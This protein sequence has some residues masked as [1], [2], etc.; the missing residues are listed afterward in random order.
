MA[1]PF[2]YLGFQSISWTCNL[3]P[4]WHDTSETHRNDHVSDKWFQHGGRNENCV[5][6]RK[7]ISKYQKKFSPCGHK[8]VLVFWLSKWWRDHLFHAWMLIPREAKRAQPC[9]SQPQLLFSW[10]TQRLLLWKLAF[11][12]AWVPTIVQGVV[13]KRATPRRGP[14]CRVD[15]GF[16]AVVDSTQT[17][18]W[19]SWYLTSN[20]VLIT[21]V[22]SSYICYVV[23]LIACASST[24]GN[25][26]ILS[27]FFCFILTSNKTSFSIIKFALI[28]QLCNI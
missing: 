5:E 15:L 19:T 18:P 9:P 22:C 8:I 4:N 1:L 25:D 24:F 14:G 11:W 10:K 20:K 17:R 27:S 28:N 13:D 21:C 12:P 26:R 6:V 23:A 3:L 2:D 16:F 7:I